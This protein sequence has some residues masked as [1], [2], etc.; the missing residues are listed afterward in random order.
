MYIKYYIFLFQKKIK[1]IF[2]IKTNTKLVIII[3]LCIFILSSKNSLQ[4]LSLVK[5]LNSIELFLLFL[6]IQINQIYHRYYNLL[7]K[8]PNYYQF[9][10]F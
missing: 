2:T 10:I 5:I 1:F 4:S 7:I 3:F 9:H 6:F 8:I